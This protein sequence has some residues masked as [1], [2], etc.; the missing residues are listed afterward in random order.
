MMMSHRRRLVAT[1]M[2]GLVLSAVTLFAPSAAHAGGGVQVT[3][4][5]HTQAWI[6]AFNYGI[7]HTDVPGRI[8]TVPRGTPIFHTGIVVPNTRVVFHYTSLTAPPPGVQFTVLSG[9]AS[10]NCVVPHEQSVLD[11]SIFGGTSW[12]VD[13]VYIAWEDNQV[14]SKILGTLVVT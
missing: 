10:S 7:L 9:F 5:Q 3:C 12:A 6:V 2:A 1:F 4:G 8:L 11:T 13:A 14:H